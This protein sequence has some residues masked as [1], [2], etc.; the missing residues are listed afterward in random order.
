MKDIPNTQ[1]RL[2]E[3]ARY[4]MVG[5]SVMIAPVLPS[6]RPPLYLSEKVQYVLE[7][8]AR[9]HIGDK[10]SAVSEPG[11]IHISAD[12]PH[13]FVNLGDVLVRIVTFFPNSSYEIN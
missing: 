1:T 4:G 11:V 12:T 9:F 8:H 5:S 2:A 10:V 6:E 13:A 7:G 3:G